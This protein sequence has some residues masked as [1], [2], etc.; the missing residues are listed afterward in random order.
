MEEFKFNTIDNIE[1]QAAKGAPAPQ[2]KPNEEQH[3]KGKPKKEEDSPNHKK[4]R[5]P[6]QKPAGV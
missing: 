1:G 6:G 3:E 5:E 4:D 2:E